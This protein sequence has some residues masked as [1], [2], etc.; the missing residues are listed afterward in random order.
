[1]CLTEQWSV[2]TLKSKIDGMLFERTAI[3]KKPVEL[4]KLEVKQ[5]ANNGSLSPDLVFKD[6]YVL[7]FLDL[8]DTYQEKDLETAIV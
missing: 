4:A 5:L 1:M 7:D 2:R 3:S 8:K 6:H